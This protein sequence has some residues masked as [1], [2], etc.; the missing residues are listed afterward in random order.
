MKKYIVL[1]LKIAVSVGIIA[2]LVWSTTR[3]E[4]KENALANLK[5]QPKNWE[6]LAAAWAV[7]TT[8]V[9][10]T[11]V[12]WWYLVRALEIPCR[13]RDALRISFWGYLFNF[14]PLGIVSG[15]V[16]K[17]VMLA[18]EHPK[19]KTKAA[20]SVFVDRVIG[21]YMLFVIASTAILLTGYLKFD[22]PTP[23]IL[24]CRATIAL[25]IVGGVGIGLLLT[26]A[27]SDGK[28]SR[29]LEG[30]PR[31]GH[32]FEKLID[33]MRMYRRKPK[34]LLL[35][36]LMSLSVHCLF[37]TSIFLIARGLPGNVP[38]LKLHFVIVPLSMVTQVIPFSIGPLELVMK[39]LY[40]NLPPAVGTIAAG[41]GFVVAIC[42]RLIT[43]LIAALG[44]YYY[45]GN[46]KEVTEAIHENQP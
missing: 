12:R 41:Q 45:F 36:S 1:F 14:F 15:D 43:L 28:L 4:G 44:I 20:A 23:I 27:V 29:W 17:I 3:G 33:T 16:V 42:Y 22:L 39:I 32:L 40:A 24:Y 13:F 11:F 8:A 2:Y 19:C 46:R 9:L 34:V 21:L 31:V 7:A 18:H 37:A 30:L 25:T 5:N 26:P 35:S 6:Y 38:P 10:L